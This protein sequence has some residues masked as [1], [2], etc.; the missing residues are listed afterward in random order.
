MKEEIGLH[1][2]KYFHC[3]CKIGEDTKINNSELSG[4]KAYLCMTQ[5]FKLIHCHISEIKENPWDHIFS[6]T[7]QQSNKGWL[8]LRQILVDNDVL[9]DD[10]IANQS[11]VSIA[12]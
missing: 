12:L 1:F 8:L 7:Q 3:R 4:P 10:V 11:D 6:K 9:A 5:E 2:L